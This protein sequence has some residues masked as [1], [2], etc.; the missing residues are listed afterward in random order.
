VL[1]GPLVFVSIVLLKVMCGAKDLE[2]GGPVG[3]TVN[4]G[5]DMVNVIAILAGGS[6]WVSAVWNSAFMLLALPEG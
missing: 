6:D 3:T 5:A 4:D 2:V 1:L